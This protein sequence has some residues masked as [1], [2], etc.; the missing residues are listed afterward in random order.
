MMNQFG[1]VRNQADPE[2]INFD[3]WQE[4]EK[5]VLKDQEIHSIKRS[6][7]TR[8][9]SS[10]VFRLLRKSGRLIGMKPP[11]DLPVKS[12]Y[13]IRFAILG[14]LSFSR[15]PDFIL[16][17]AKAAYLYD[18]TQ[19]WVTVDAVTRFIEDTGI[20]VLFVSHPTFCQRLQPRLKGCRV[21]YVPEAVDPNEYLNDEVKTID[22]LSFGRVLKS[23]Q[24]DLLTGLPPEVK[25]QHGYV[26]NR[27]DLKKA[28]GSARIIINFPRSLTDENMDVD[29]LTMRY[30][31]SMASKALLLGRCPSILKDL[32]GY[33]PVIAADFSNPSQ[34]VQSILSDFSTYQELIE[35]NYQTLIAGHTFWHRWLEIKKILND[36]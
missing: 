30:L 22:L 23:Y 25:F 36:E 35:K 11:Y 26:K 20:S 4:F 28:M 19:P 6:Q 32:F 12:K 29:M 5:S 18:A 16:K 17:G 2:S 8:V 1:L 9:L 10:V 3:D 33:D 14:G 13:A 31:Q 34:Q 27:S 7:P 21:Y 24:N 15:C